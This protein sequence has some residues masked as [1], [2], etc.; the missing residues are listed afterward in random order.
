MSRRSWMTPRNVNTRG[1]RVCLNTLG[2]RGGE[3]AQGLKCAVQS[4]EGGGG[5]A[6]FV[7][8]GAERSLQEGGTDCFPLDLRFGGQDGVNVEAEA[9]VYVAAKN[10]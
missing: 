9:T 3:I 6:F 7:G 4:V 1:P 8:M 10:I 5:P 2:A